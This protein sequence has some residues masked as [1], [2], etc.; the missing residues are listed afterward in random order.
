MAQW[1]LALELIDG[2]VLPV[3]G[4]AATVLL[5]L[6][7]VRRRRRPWLLIA[8][9]LVGA[10]VALIAVWLM[11][12]SHLFSI[13]VPEQAMLWTAVALGSAG[14]GVAALWGRPFRATMLAAG[15]V[16]VS[17]VTGALGVN[18]AFDITHNLA[19]LIGVQAVDPVRLP[20][21]VAAAPSTEPLYETWT[22]PAGMPQHGLIGAL[23]G[24]DRIAATGF[25]ARDGAIYLPPAALVDD[26]PPLPLLVFM[27]GKPGA[28]EPTPVARALDDF[29]AAHDGLAPIAIIADQLSS[30]IVDP[31]CHDSAA[32]GDVATYFTADIPTFAT[33]RLNITAD[34]ASWVI[35]G[36]SNG[37]A[38]A[39]LFGAAHPE[40]YGNILDVSGDEYPGVETID[41][42]IAQVFNGDR[43]AFEAAKPAAVMQAN[44]GRFDGHDAVFTTG[45]EDTQNGPGQ[46]ANAAAAEAA[47]F[48]VTFLTIAGAGHVGSALDQGLA[49]GLEALAVPLGL[50]P[51]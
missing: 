43:E 4:V 29:A 8:G 11:D 41:A 51:P 27:M 34:P 35:G 28:P 46:E 37:G 33:E 49:Q 45:S 30:P 20:A 2:P 19:A 40:I 13:A 24:P 47:G 32:F 17:L 38:C 48:T 22:A 16:V 10:G 3:W 26:P 1:L 39:L 21:K 36:Y 25:A 14:V 6:V 7:A 5:V 9:A 31:A 12:S 15:L 42:T 44:A 50:A 23:S 18:R